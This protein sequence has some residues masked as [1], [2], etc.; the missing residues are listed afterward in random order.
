MVINTSKLNGKNENVM[1]TF[2]EESYNLARTIATL[3]SPGSMA[4]IVGSSGAGKSRLIQQI[5][6]EA[7]G[8]PNSWSGGK[9]PAIKVNAS[10]SDRAYFSPRALMHAMLKALCNIFCSSPADIDSWPIANDLKDAT[11]RAMRALKASDISESTMRETVLELG[12]IRELKTIFV[13]EG[14]LMCLTQRHR[15]PTDYLESLK[16]LA[17]ELNIRIVV[18]AT[19]D[20]LEVW[21]HTA[22][23]NRR[24][25]TIH[26]KR[27]RQEVKKEY[28]DFAGIVASFETDYELKKGILTKKLGIIY[29]NTYGIPGEVASLIERAIEM[30]LADSKK[31]VEWSDFQEAFHYPAQLRQLM[32]EADAGELQLT[33]DWAKAEALATQAQADTEAG[34]KTKKRSKP[35]SRPVDYPVGSPLICAAA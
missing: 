25:R 18:A 3:S 5:Y 13:D 35:M 28:A 22:Q 12:L 19:Y 2:Y 17:I 24:M 9:I 30:A 15:F 29:Q 20:I 10:N 34:E 31:K 33:R 23:I 27:Y 4:L 1:H 26:L 21:N 11:K 7:F 32:K 14:N 16:A 6:N 8:S